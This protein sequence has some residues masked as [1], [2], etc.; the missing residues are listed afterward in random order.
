MRLRLCR[1][2]PDCNVHYS[3]NVDNGGT[4]KTVSYREHDLAKPVASKEGERL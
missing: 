1:I 2:E 4:V 3:D